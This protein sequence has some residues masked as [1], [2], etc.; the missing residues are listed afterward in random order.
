[1]TNDSEM[2]I[3]VSQDELEALAEGLLAPASQDRLDELLRQNANSQLSA[4]EQCELDLLLG[5]VDQLNI[6]KARARYTL[7]HQR[8]GATGA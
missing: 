7:R 4:D 2:L 8:T 3:G 6:L 1:M 5:R